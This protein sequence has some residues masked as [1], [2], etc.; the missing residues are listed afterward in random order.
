MSRTSIATKRKNAVAVV[1]TLALLLVLALPFVDL[2]RTRPSD[3]GCRGACH[4]YLP[5]VDPARGVQD[6]RF[7]APDPYEKAPPP[8]S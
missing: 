8:S 6:F 7:S 1:L 5:Q 2:G 4:R 3:D